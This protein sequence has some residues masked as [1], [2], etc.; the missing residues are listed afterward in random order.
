MPGMKLNISLKDSKLIGK[1]ETFYR[2]STLLE[3]RIRF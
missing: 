1:L 2:G 3:K